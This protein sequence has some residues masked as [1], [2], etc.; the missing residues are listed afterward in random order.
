[1]TLIDFQ[2]SYSLFHIYNY[3]YFMIMN[4]VYY[5]NK[6]MIIHIIDYDNKFVKENRRSYKD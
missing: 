1:M 3:A 4:F 5:N 6:F 2:I